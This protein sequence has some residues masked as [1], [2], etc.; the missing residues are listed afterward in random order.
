MALCRLLHAKGLSSG[1]CLQ[2]QL[3]EVLLLQSACKDMHTNKA[4]WSHTLHLA[5]KLLSALP[6]DLRLAEGLCSYC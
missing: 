4:E 5:H 6:W 3:Q 2:R 1:M